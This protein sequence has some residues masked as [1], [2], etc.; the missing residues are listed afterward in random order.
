MEQIRKVRGAEFLN[1][2]LRLVA[3]SLIVNEH[4]LRGAGGR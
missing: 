4:C 2:V 1:V 3:L